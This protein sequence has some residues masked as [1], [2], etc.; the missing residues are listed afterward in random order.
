MNSRRDFIQKLSAPLIALPFIKNL[1]VQEIPYEG[2]VLRIA[3]M[4]LGGYATRVAEAMQFCNKAKVVGLISGT[5]S[6]IKAWREKYNIVE[7]NCYDYNNF[8]AIKDNKEIDAVYIITPNALHK[9][10]AIRV[11][12]TGKH[13]IVE[14]P[15][16]LNA[17]EASEM[18]DACKKAGVQLLVGYRMHFEPKTLEVIRMRK[19][20][21][22]GKIKFFQGLTGFRIGDPKQWRLNKQLA[23]GGSMMDIGIYAINGMRYMTGEEPIWVTAQETKT[24]PVKFAEGVDETIQFQAGFPSGA[25]ASCLSSYGMSNLDRFFLNGEKGFAEMQPSTGYGPIKGRTHKGELMQVHQ[26][27]Q[28]V[29]MEEFAAILLE[30]KTPIVPADGE[31]GL[32]DMKIIDAIYQAVKTGKKVRLS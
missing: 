32:K 5:P 12:G 10:Q 24:D 19:D 26:A 16:A 23:G 22:F 7:S 6:K 25:I 4:G 29:Q 2:P 14:K 15:M 1:G 13:V 3:I 21:E 20:G 17:K 11:A 30:G 27:H 18:I 9:E 31:E 28:T 8:E